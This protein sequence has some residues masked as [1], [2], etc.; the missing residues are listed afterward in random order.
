MPRRAYLRTTAVSLV[1][2]LGAVSALL[3]L[4]PARGATLG[5][6]EIDADALSMQSALYSDG[7]KDW[8]LGPGQGVF[9][10][11]AG[12]VTDCF[13]SDVA[14]NPA[15]G[16]L[17]SFLCDG[18]SDSRFDGNGGD[19]VVEPEQNIVGPGGKQVSDLW[20]I[21]PGSV[22][23]KDDFSHAYAFFWLGDS[24]CDADTLADDPFIALGGHRGDNE[25]DAF[26][27]FELND[28]A[29][30]GFPALEANAGA[31]FDLDFNRT[32]SDLLISITLTGGGTNPLLEVFR[33]DGLT[34]APASSSCAANPSASQGDS[35]LRT[36]P[37]ADILAPPWNIP[38]CD[39]TGTNGANT[40]RIVNGAG[41]PPAA[42]GDNRI[43]PRDFVESVI[44]LHA[45]G[46]GDV[47]F[48][49]LIFTS[50]SAHPL[51]TADLKDVGGVAVDTCPPPAPSPPAAPPGAPP[52]APPNAPPPANPPG[53]SGPP[54]RFPPTGGSPQSA[55]TDY[56]WLAVLLGTATTVVAAATLRR[57]LHRR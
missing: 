37:S 23:G 49:S 44:D 32:P 19:T 52:N 17:A 28:I 21:K 33:W 36:N 54:V 45:F 34:F 3:V 40:C 10:L 8:S 20:P 51:S 55:A 53:G 57:L 35:L 43:A 9:V 7:G 31:S 46:V 16:G 14:P 4:S 27:G 41:T 1:F 11:G 39:P 42:P 2:A 13:G 56:A 26:W 5:G 48:S 18:S 25:G 29:P 38:A 30:T 47:C 15:S 12:G 6:F 22:T 50:R 24:S